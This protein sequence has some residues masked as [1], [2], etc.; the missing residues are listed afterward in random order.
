LFELF[1]RA[2]VVMYFQMTGKPFGALVINSLFEFLS[3]IQ[4]SPHP[5]DGRSRSRWGTKV[6]KCQSSG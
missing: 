3:A 2:K 6:G 4:D 5:W 1:V